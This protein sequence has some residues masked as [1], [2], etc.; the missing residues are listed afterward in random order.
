VVDNKFSENNVLENEQ[1]TKHTLA[2][3]TY[4]HRRFVTRQQ[5]YF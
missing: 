2:V 4:A 5:W 1:I 3:V